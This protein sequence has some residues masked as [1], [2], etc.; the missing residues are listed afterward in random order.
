MT[1]PTSPAP[2][3]AAPAAQK[4][5]T[6]FTFYR[7]TTDDTLLRL[8]PDGIP[9]VLWPDGSWHPYPDVDIAT[10]AKP[11]TPDGAATLA[12]GA[13]LNAPRESSQPDAAQRQQ[14]PAARARPSAPQRQQQ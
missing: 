3:T 1:Q 6:G 12:A 14:Q 8:G 4:P 11:L 9:D 13:D 7:D 5:A 10:E 2:P